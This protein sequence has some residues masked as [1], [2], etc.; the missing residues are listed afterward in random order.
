VSARDFWPFAAGIRRAGREWWLRVH[1]PHAE[2]VDLDA[3]NGALRDFVNGTT[4]SR[5]EIVEFLRQFDPP[6][7]PSGIAWRGVDVGLVR[8]PPS[9]TWTRRRAHTFALAEDWLGTAA[10]SESEGLE[11]LTRRY[12]AGFGPATRNDLADWA[13]VPVTFFHD[14]LERL[15]LRRFRSEDGRELLDLPRAPRPSADTPAPVRLL[16]KFDNVLLDRQR[17]LP[18][19]Y[20]TL[21]V[22]KNAD[23]QPTFTV[24]GYVAG[25]WRVE[26]HHVVTKPF[27][28][29]PRAAQRE[30]ED[31]RA[32]LEAW[33][34]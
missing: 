33:L 11:H 12:F 3:A 2:R 15:R 34:G 25:V 22:R 14:V 21:V 4:R 1:K 24:D 10:V 27:A 5:A 6:G 26:K 9:G 23:V 19:E 16:P 17:V 30:L 29:L 18:D 7:A 13:G 8:A 28:P 20:R 32:R 31:E